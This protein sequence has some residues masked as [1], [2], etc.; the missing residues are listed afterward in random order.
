MLPS[1]GLREPTITAAEKPGDAASVYVEA[2]KNQLTP[3]SQVIRITICN[4]E[5]ISIQIPSGGDGLL[6]D[7]LGVDGFYVVGSLGEAIARLKYIIAKANDFSDGQADLTV[8][9]IY[10]HSK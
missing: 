5:N 7:M 9:G 2:G 6:A 3:D 8:G 10:E 1:L 4:S